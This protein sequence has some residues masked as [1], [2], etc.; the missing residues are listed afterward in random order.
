MAITDTARQAQRK[1]QHWELV[2]SADASYGVH[3]GV[4][5]DAIVRYVTQ[6]RWP[7]YGVTDNAA[8][9]SYING[10][11]RRLREYET[12]GLLPAGNSAAASSET[13]RPPAENE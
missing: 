2:G 5:N 4:T 13:V 11:R 1:A 8:Q 7:L 6:N 3:H 9:R 12:I 10:V